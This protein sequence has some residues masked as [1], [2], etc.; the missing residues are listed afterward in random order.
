MGCPR[1]IQLRPWCQIRYPST[2][3]LHGPQGLRS[4]VRRHCSR[5]C[6]LGWI[7]RLFGGSSRKMLWL[8]RIAHQRAMLVMQV[9]QE[10]LHLRAM[11][12]VESLCEVDL[13]LLS[14]Q[15]SRRGATYPLFYR[16]P[17]AHLRH[18]SNYERLGIPHAEGLKAQRP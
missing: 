12:F 16:G 1:A 3:A 9:L 13:L 8:W 10:P 6:I 14:C 4:A 15:P 17:R 7:H 2:C 5:S 11:P 18:T